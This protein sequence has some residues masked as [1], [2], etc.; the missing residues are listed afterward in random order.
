METVLITGGT[1]LVGRYLTKK[2]LKKGYVVKIL[3]RGTRKNI[4]KIRYYHWDIAN[5][6]IPKEAFTNTTA[7]IHLSGAN[8]AEK[9]WTKSRKKE[10]LGSRVDS[11]NLLYEGLKKYNH[12]VETFISA[13]GIGYYGVDITE[14]IFLESDPPAKDFLAQVC[15]QWEAASLKIE[16]LGIRRTVLRTGV[17]FAKQE[18]ALQKMATPYFWGLGMAIGSGKQTINWIDIDDLCRMYLFALQNENI[19]GAYNAVAPYPITNRDFGK[20]LSKKIKRPFWKCKIPGL[21]LKIVFGEMAEI[22]L[23]GS[24]ASS[25][26]IENK[27]FYFKNTCPLTRI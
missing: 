11:T 23:G 2:L 7:I 25:K 21:V 16:N 14:H 27:G 12:K 26:S 4:Y 1:G 5:K 8:V 3:S 9:R 13:S 6:K 10:L 19:A 15:V 20:K 18:S 24:A 17:V 22:L